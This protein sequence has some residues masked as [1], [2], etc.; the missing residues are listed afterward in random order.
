MKILSKLIITSTFLVLTLFACSP[1]VDDVV[2]G[3]G[4]YVIFT[5]ESGS[6]AEGSTISNNV[7][8]MTVQRG[9]TADYS[10]DVTIS[11]TVSAVDESGADASAQIT[12]LTGGTATIVAGETEGGIQIQSNG[13]ADQDGNVIVTV[14][15]TSVSGGLNAGFPGPDGLNSEF[16][17]TINDDDCP[18]DATVYEG[19]WA[20]DD[21]GNG[22][23]AATSHTVTISYLGTSG[24]V[25]QFELS[26]FH[27]F[28][29]SINFAARS[30]V[31]EF[32]LFTQTW[33]IPDQ[34]LTPPLGFTGSP[35]FRAVS[36]AAGNFST[37]SP[38]TMTINYVLYDSSPAAPVGGG[39]LTL[40]R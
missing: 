11:Y 36:T 33:T 8:P 31:I 34:E 35:R 2:Y 14:K 3:D 39:L 16:T 19:D 20:A 25:E 40:T 28:V 13:D 24:S 23:S 12:D 38:G 4:G 9:G 15:I 7:F 6:M 5:T 37:C 17:L 21:P 1:E 10:G 27:G 22:W 18:F 30:V 32:D 26:N 29:E